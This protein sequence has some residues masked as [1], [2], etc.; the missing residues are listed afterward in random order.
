MSVLSIGEL[1]DLG[2]AST[3]GLIPYSALGYNSNNEISGISGS[4]IA[5]GGSVDS[6]T[7]SSIASSYAESAVSGC[8]PYSSFEYSAGTT[9]I[10]AVSGSA[11][12]GQNFNPSQMRLVIDSATMSAGSSESGIE[13][14][15][16]SGVFQPTGAYATGASVVVVADSAQATASDVV[17]V[18]TGV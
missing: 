10:T 13:I 16:K 14:G 4:A 6:A 3:A 7:V 2:S 12:A 17:Y 1:L 9:L 15:V 8:V 11:I 18:V 5:G